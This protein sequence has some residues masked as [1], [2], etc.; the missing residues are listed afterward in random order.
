MS[1]NVTSTV[2]KRNR[3]LFSSYHEVTSQW[4]VK[5]GLERAIE[6]DCWKAGVE[7]DG[8]FVF[9]DVAVFIAPVK[10]L[11]DINFALRNYRRLV[12]WNGLI[13]IP[14]ATTVY[15]LKIY[16]KITKRIALGFGISSISAQ[17][18]IL[19][20]DLLFTEPNGLEI[21]VL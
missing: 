1:G 4:V 2:E 21:G 7:L 3:L 14:L 9:A 15:D 8:N 16:D 11:G 19:P 13:C 5:E 20:Q 17:M 10:R 6:H 18:E 12:C